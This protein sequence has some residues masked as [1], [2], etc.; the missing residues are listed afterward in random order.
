MKMY[1]T[2]N[3]FVV[4]QNAYWISYKDYKTQTTQFARMTNI[5]PFSIFLTTVRNKLFIF[6]QLGEK[7]H[8]EIEHS[9][10]R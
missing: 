4:A 8:K 1:L 7:C 2:F 3:K 10:R 6:Y 5:V 9:F